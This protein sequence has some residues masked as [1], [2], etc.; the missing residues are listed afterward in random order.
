[1]AGKPTLPVIVV[2]IG[3]ATA[4]SGRD[5]AAA[6]VREAQR[7]FARSDKYAAVVIAID[8]EIRDYTVHLSRDG[9]KLVSARIAAASDRLAYRNDKAHWGPHFQ[10]AFFANKDRRQVIVQF[11]DV[12]G[13]LKLTAGWLGSA[14]APRPAS[15][16]RCRS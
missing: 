1:M 4:Y 16:S 12:V 7:R 5:W 11:E 10:V 15:Q 13:K 8:A 2:Q 3:S 14:R 9:A 6:T